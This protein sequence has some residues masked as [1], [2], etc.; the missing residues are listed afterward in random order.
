VYY[1]RKLEGGYFPVPPQNTRA[2]RW[3]TNNLCL[4]AM[5][6]ARHLKVD[7]RILNQLAKVMVD[8]GATGNFMHLEFMK[9][10]GLLG[11]AKAAPQPITDLN[12]ENLGTLTITTKSETVPMVV[13]GHIKWLNFDI[14]PTGRY[15]VVLGIPWLR[16]HNPAI[17]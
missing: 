2:P 9:K 13:L 10:L 12:G 11:K 3:E 1:D 5:K 14:I 6:N 4:A 15:D 16:S 8:L 7:A 17:N